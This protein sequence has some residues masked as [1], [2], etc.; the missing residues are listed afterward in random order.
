MSEQSSSFTVRSY[1]VMN[2][3]DTRLRFSPFIQENKTDDEIRLPVEL[4]KEKDNNGWPV[5]DFHGLPLC[6][7]QNLWKNMG[8]RKHK[9]GLLFAGFVLV[10]TDVS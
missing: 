7:K 2:Y 9:F 5:S 3:V 1:F 4:M 10:Q 8:F 6:F